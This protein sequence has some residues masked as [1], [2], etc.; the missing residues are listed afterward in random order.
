MREAVTQPIRDSCSFV[1][2]DRYIRDM[3][4]R[5]GVAVCLALCGLA[6]LSGCT[7]AVQFG[8]RL[9]ADGTVDYITCND[10]GSP[11]ICVD[12]EWGREDGPI[13]WQAASPADSDLNGV[14]VHY[15]E[16]PAGFTGPAA[17]PVPAEWDRVQFG[18]SNI[19]RDELVVGEW[20]WETGEPSFVPDRPCVDVPEGS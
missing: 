14:V 13:E 17:A 7:P 18:F 8:A 4:R 9:N 1:I 12:Y 15:G 3:I 20:V 6:V 11:S 10:W 5:A 2:P 16:T 19:G